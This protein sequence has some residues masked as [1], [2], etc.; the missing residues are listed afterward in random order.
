MLTRILI[1][2]LAFILK[3]YS[4]IMVIEG[5]GGQ[6]ERERG[7]QEILSFMGSS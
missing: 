2:L 3:F 6:I 1:I 4:Y 5:V 7:G